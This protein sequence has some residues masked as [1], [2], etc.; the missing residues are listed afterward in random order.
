MTLELGQILTRKL[1]Y[2]VYVPFHFLLGGQHLDSRVPNIDLIK[3]LCFEYQSELTNPPTRPI[4]LTEIHR[5]YPVQ[6]SGL[7]GTGLSGSGNMIILNSPDEELESL[8]GRSLGPS[9]L[10]YTG[11]RR[12]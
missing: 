12:L 1:A 9:K 3:K 6:G 11:K 4:T 7:S 10:I 8:T 5:S 2:S